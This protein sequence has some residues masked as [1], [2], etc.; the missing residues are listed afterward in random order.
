RPQW[1]FGMSTYTFLGRGKVAA[2]YTR[3]G[4]DYLAVYEDGAW[5]ALDLPYTAFQPQLVAW[6]GRLAFL[7]AGPAQP[8]ALVACDPAT[9]RTEVL[10]SSF[11]AAFDA[12]CVSTP[13]SISFPT[14]GGQ[15]AHAIFYPPSNPEFE[16]PEGERPPL[17]VISHGGPTSQAQPRFDPEIAFWTS[18]GLALVDVNYRGS[19]GYGRGYRDLLNGQW[20][21]ADVDDCL[22]AARYLTQRGEVDGRRLIIRGGSAGGYTTLCALTFHDDFQAGASYYG[23]ADLA[24][25]ETDTHKFESKYLDRLVGPWPEEAQ[26]FH[27]RSPTHF[28]DRLSC[29]IILFQ[30]L[31]DKV[32]PPSQASMMAEALDAKGLPYVHR[33]FP[34]EGHGFRDAKN[35]RQ[36]LE[37][38]LS[39]YS[40]IFGFPLADPI[41]AV[42]IRNSTGRE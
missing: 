5:R 23:V 29:P 30:G 15:T 27:D 35:V 32:V 28:T 17:I 22:N 37:E 20:G 26:L 31:E 9:G 4:F 11:E 33:E 34:G 14:T 10:R 13:R 24:A 41:P 18:R 16:A 42:P 8:T 19:S 7:A 2:I 40:Q 6:G 38:E 36:A 12:G 21:V 39:F 1:V 25:L 3:D